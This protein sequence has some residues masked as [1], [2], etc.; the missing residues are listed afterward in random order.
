MSFQS[1]IFDILSLTHQEKEV[2]P[3][4]THS[5]LLPELSCVCIPN[6]RLLAPCIFLAKLP[7]LAFFLFFSFFLFFNTERGVAI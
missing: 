2:W 7:L 3:S 6:F 4:G 1:S 5:M